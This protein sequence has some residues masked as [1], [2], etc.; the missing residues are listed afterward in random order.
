MKPRYIWSLHGGA[1]RA[2]L[3]R[4]DPRYEFREAWCG[5]DLHESV[6]RNRARVGFFK[7]R[8]LSVCPRCV[9]AKS[10]AKH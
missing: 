2:H 7:P 4:K 5:D 9:E 1:T 8:H 3:Y 10:R 6:G